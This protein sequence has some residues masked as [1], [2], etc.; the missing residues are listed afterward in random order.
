M[1]NY[2]LKIVYIAHDIILV[3]LIDIMEKQIVK[4][5]KKFL[6]NILLNHQKLKQKQK[7]EKESGSF[8]SYYRDLT[9]VNVI[10]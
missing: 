8:Y 9:S 7:P 1:V 5:L 4:A 10:A 3:F 2:C 6:K